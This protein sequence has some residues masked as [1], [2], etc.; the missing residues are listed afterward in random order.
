MII[1]ANSEAFEHFIS[2]SV[3]Y[4]KHCMSNI[5]LEYFLQSSN[6]TYHIYLGM[7]SF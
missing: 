5:L 1:T 6:V 3:F 4:G 2:T 7:Y